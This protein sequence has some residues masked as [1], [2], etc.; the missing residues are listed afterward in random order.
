ME[1]NTTPLAPAITGLRDPEGVGAT[2]EQG[3]DFTTGQ[4]MRAAAG[5][6]FVTNPA[7]ALRDLYEY[8]A[9][10]VGF[11]REKDLSP[12]EANQQYQHLGLSFNRPVSRHYADILAEQKRQ[13]IVRQ[14]VMDRGPQGVLAT[15]GKFAAGFGVSALDPINVAS[16]FIPP[17]GATR[18]AQVAR[19]TS[20]VGQRAITG[21]V[22]GALGAAAIEPLVL[23]GASARQADYDITDSLLNVTFG[24]VLG[25]GLHVAGGYVSDKFLARK[26]AS[27]LAPGTVQM[28]K[29]TNVAEVVEQMPFEQRETAMR[30]AIGQVADGQVVNVGD[31]MRTAPQ[32]PGQNLLGSVQT[33][34]DSAGKAYDTQFEV[35]EAKDLVAASGDLQPRDR[36]RVGSDDQINRLAIDMIPE[37][38][39]ESTDAATGAPIVGPDNMVESGNGRVSFIRQAYNNGYASGEKY[40]AFLKSRGVEVSGFKQP[41]LVRRRLTPLDDNERRG[42]VVNAQAVGT[43]ALSATE[44]ASA[45]ARLVDQALELVPINTPNLRAGANQKFVRAFLSQIPQSERAGLITSGGELAQAGLARIRNGLLARAFDDADLL[46]SILEEADDNLRTLGNALYEIAIPWA[47]MRSAVRT[48]EISPYVDATDDL[49]NAVRF[50]RKAKDTDIPYREAVTQGELGELKGRDAR[51]I[52]TNQMLSLMLRENERGDYRLV[53]KELLTD[54]ISKYV[55]LARNTVPTNDMF[56]APPA[57]TGDLLTALRQQV[58]SDAQRLGTPANVVPVP[59]GGTVRP[60]RT[61]ISEADLNTIRQEAYEN[62]GLSKQ[63]LVVPP[64]EAKPIYAT[65]ENTPPERRSMPAQAAN[66]AVVDDAISGDSMASKNALAEAERIVS[67]KEAALDESIGELEQMLKGTGELTPE[68]QAS[69]A[70]ADQFINNQ[71][72]IREAIMAAATCVIGR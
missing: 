14:T 18:L 5:A 63:D 38:L 19:I 42:F 23:A 8:G 13:E 37:R 10:R 7:M 1:P 24:T 69:L 28:P 46:N 31:I 45:D 64:K 51:T 12:D 49:L 59:D 27:Q 21:A 36:T 48:G 66:D 25:T 9:D 3:L 56:G 68:E 44:R 43:M 20:T 41:V 40:K 26:A 61:A 2:L 11:L 62:V 57:G 60:A 71:P 54:R 15:A 6:A 53:S 58:I 39:A 67:E 52:E 70:E 30:T 47:D 33:V 32:S 4:S 50:L 34:Y 72:T 35:V 17:L 16:A 65:A 22:G 55:E 29:P